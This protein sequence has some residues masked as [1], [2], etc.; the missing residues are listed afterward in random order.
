VSY[1]LGAIG[2]VL[3]VCVWWLASLR[4]P[5]SRLVSPFA[6]VSDIRDNFRHAP[7]LNAYG[8]G[9]LG[10]GSLLAYTAKNVALG[11]TAGTVG[12]VAC[13]LI[14]ARFG[15]IRT[16]TEPAFLVLGNVPILA[17]APLLLLWFGV[18]PVSQV[19]L[20]AVY[21]FLLLTQFSL[22]AAQNLDPVYEARA[23]TAG[24]STGLRLWVLFPGVVPEIVGGI[25]I[26]LAFGWGLEVFAETLG[27]R[28]GIG[29]GMEAFANTFNT[30][31]LLALVVLVGILAVLSDQL[32]TTAARAAT[33][34]R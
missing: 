4:L 13:G 29:Q 34:W 26:S 24:A 10:Y 6:V 9:E 22:R 21:T 28:S 1:A 15:R 23:A 32:V 7:S 17:L 5:A 18:V 25:R 19:I 27:A 16:A 12:G 3:F 31:S 20:V 30:Q 33:P 14:F 8:L 2:L 11:I